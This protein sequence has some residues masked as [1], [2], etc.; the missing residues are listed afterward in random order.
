MITV[1][2]DQYLRYEIY[3]EC[4]EDFDDE[5]PLSFDEWLKEESRKR[6]EMYGD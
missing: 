6:A 4:C 3:L 1:Y 2:S 5:E